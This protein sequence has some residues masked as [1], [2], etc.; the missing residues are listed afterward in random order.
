VLDAETPLI[1]VAATSGPAAS[2]AVHLAERA[3]AIGSTVIGI[4]GSELSRAA[5]YHLPGPTLPETVAPLALV[6]PGQLLVEKL[7]RRRGIDPDRPRNLAKV[8]QTAS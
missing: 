6:V 5:T 1:A 3:R 7:A 8:T 4:G 2:G